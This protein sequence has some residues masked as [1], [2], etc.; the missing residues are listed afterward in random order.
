MNIKLKSINKEPK[1]VK[2]KK[3]KVALILLLYAP[4]KP[5]K[6]NIG[7]IA[8]SNDKKKKNKFNELKATIIK[9][10]ISKKHNK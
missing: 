2:R 5:I 3:K 1:N 7:N 9:N 6:I 4:F 8:L 10:S